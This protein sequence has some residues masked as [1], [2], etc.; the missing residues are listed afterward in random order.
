MA[1]GKR[2]YWIK[3][4]ESFFDDDGPVDFMMSQPSGANYVVL[5]QMLCL[6]TINTEGRLSNKIGEVLIQYDIKKIQ[7]TCKYFSEDTIRVALNLY[8]SLGLI[9]EETSGT[10]V[11]SNHHAMVGSETDWA[12]QKRDQRQQPALPPGNT[13]E[14]AGVDNDVDNVHTDIRDTDIRDT[15]NRDLD[16]EI[17][18]DTTLSA[19]QS[20]PC[21]F[22]KIRNLYHKI[23]IS[24][25]AIKKIDGERRKAVAA[26]WRTYKTLDT[27]EQLFTIA[28]S[29]TFLKGQ[30][31]RNWIADFDWMMK[32]SNFS[33]ILEHKYDDRA[34][35]PS[36]GVFGTLA[37]LHEE[38]GYDATGNG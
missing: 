2:Y 8:R 20:G 25:P 7:R 21:P 1:T 4:K 11:M 5:Y 24:F 23:C 17:E 22:S 28:E 10:L 34:A 12:A 31:D 33:K 3:L 29:S 32:A 9:Y 13:D 16:T 27:F 14:G 6:K 37:K 15:D 26:R 18:E 35:K 19:P 36:G 30:N 38:A